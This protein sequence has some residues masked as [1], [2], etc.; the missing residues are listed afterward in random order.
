L[1]YFILKFIIISIFCLGFLGSAACVS[2]EKRLNFVK[3][4]APFDLKCQNDRISYSR[5]RKNRFAAAGCGKRF[6]YKVSCKV[7]I[8]SKCEVI[9]IVS[10]KKKIIETVDSQKEALPNTKPTDEIN[11]QPPS[12]NSPKDQTEPPIK[13]EPPQEFPL[14]LPTN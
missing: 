11:T 14:T 7:E 13:E 4:V 9:K 5:I 6:T 8:V 1:E 3:D 12:E 2:Q 10:K